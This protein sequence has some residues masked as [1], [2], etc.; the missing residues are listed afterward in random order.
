VEQCGNMGMIVVRE[1]EEGSSIIGGGAARVV[2]EQV[3]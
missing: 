1:V 2:S 3:A